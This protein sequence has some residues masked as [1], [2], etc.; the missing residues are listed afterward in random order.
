MVSEL[1]EQNLIVQSWSTSDLLEPVDVLQQTESW[2]GDLELD[3][4]S[5]SSGVLQ[6]PFPGPHESWS[7][8]EPCSTCSKPFHVVLKTLQLLMEAGSQPIRRPSTVQWNSSDRSLVLL[9]HHS[10]LSVCRAAGRWR[11]DCDSWWS[12]CLL[13]VTTWTA[14]SLRGTPHQLIII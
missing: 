1:T 2:S 10:D 12:Y 7:E 9:V 4:H 8:S 14:A 11:L 6:E 3:N 5:S 13:L